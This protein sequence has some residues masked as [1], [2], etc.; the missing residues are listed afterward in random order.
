MLTDKALSK[1]IS[2]S[3]RIIPMTKSI[4]ISKDNRHNK[5]KQAEAVDTFQQIHKEG[6]EATRQERHGKDNSRYK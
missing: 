6:L 3:T 4:R 2:V 5:H 1:L